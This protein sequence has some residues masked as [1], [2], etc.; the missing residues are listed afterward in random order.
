MPP[1][2]WGRETAERYGDMALRAQVLL[3]GVP[4]HDAWWVDLT[5][6][7]PGR[8]ML[9]VLA[10]AEDLMQSRELGRVVPLL[11]ALRNAIGRPLG[12]DRSP[13]NERDWS[14]RSRLEP[15]D[16][17]DSLLPPGTRYG[18]FTL[19]Y[20]HRHE[21][22]SEIRNATV[23]AFLVMA[24]TEAAA[25]YRLVW[26]VHVLPVGRVTRWYLA[27]IAPFRRLVVYPAILKGLRQMWWR[28]REAPLAG[29]C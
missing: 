20:L 23:H 7:G 21:A 6:G 10:T 15:L 12:W 24:L 3:A 18:P 4:L 27:A 13:A 22:V 8:T 26:A 28:R 16:L 5:G 9:D 1:R 29:P 11:F 17:A 19:L 25:G 14:Y 2:H